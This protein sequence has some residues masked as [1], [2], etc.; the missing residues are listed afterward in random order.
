[1]DREIDYINFGSW[2]ISKG[3]MLN[4]DEDGF[5][6]EDYCTDHKWKDI[7]DLIIEY[8]EYLD[9]K[10]NDYPLND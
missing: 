10:E 2:L 7:F 5:W 6:F 3:Y 9:S 1:M 8:N 4:I